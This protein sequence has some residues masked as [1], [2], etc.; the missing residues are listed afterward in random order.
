[1]GNVGSYSASGLVHFSLTMMANREQPIPALGTKTPAY[2]G[3]NERDSGTLLSKRMSINHSGALA[4]S[5]TRNSSKQAYYTARLM[6][7]RDKMDDFLRAYAYFRWA[8][9]VI[10][11][12]ARSEEER[13]SFIERQRTIIDGLYQHEE[14]NDLTPEERM[15]ADLIQNDRHNS[16]GLQSFVRNM[17]AIIEFDACRKGSLIS[18]KELAWYTDRVGRSVTDGLLHFVGNGHPYS[19]SESRYLAAT[20]A[21]IA[22]LLRDMVRD[23]AV[24]FVNIPRE[25]LATHGI[26]PDEFG[27]PPYRTWVRERVHHARKHFKEGKF[28]LDELE[29]LRTKVVGYWYCARFE[30]VLDRI[31]R[32]EYLL[33]DSYDERRRISTWLMIGRLGIH[34]TV[35]H[36]VR[37]VA[38]ALG[39]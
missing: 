15:V 8:D 6:V 13:I 26:R 29:V 27:S 11:I 31:E 20:A 5:I 35:R 10:D 33:R 23:T 18:R 19:P 4:Q 17:L 36:F 34:V 30:A 2:N 1:M 9:D 37:R 39:F 24:G 7:D 21:H 12:H 22:H 14:A 28:Y 3:V 25:Y 38:L 32:D 16:S